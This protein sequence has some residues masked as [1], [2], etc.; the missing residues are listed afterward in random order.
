MLSRRGYKSCWEYLWKHTCLYASFTLAVN[1][2]ILIALLSTALFLMLPYHLW[3][4]ISNFA[5]NICPF[6]FWDE[7]SVGCFLCDF[8]MSEEMR[9]FVF[10]S[11]LFVNAK[12]N[13]IVV[14]RLM[15]FCLISLFKFCFLVWSNLLQSKRSHIWREKC[16]G[17]QNLSAK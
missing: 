4:Y 10:Q 16:W 14:D 8:C 11:S 2:V 7:L 13:L 3:F 6:F 15:H 1:F 5:S 17:Y 9:R 12:G